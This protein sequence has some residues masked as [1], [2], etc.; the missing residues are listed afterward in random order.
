MIGNTILHY[1]ITKKLGEGGMGV[2]YKA[3]D[4]KLMREVALKF[5]SSQ[6][7]A[8]EEERDRFEREARAAAA[9]DHPNICPIYEI[10][11]ADGQRFIAMAFVEGE[12]LQSVVRQGPLPFRDILNYAI[13]IADGLQAA[14]EKGIVHRDVKP[15]NILFSGK[16][17]VRITDF[18][19]A[20]FAGQTE[21]TK[22]GSSLGTVAYMS[23]EQTQGIEVDHRTDVWALGAVIYEMITGKRPFVGDYDQAVIY[24]IINQDP[25]PPTGLRSGVPM[26]LE[27]IVSKSLAKNRDERYQHIEEMLVDLK[28]VQKTL[29]ASNSITSGSARTGAKNVPGHSSGAQGRSPK[30]KAGLLI[31]IPFVLILVVLAAYGFWGKRDSS[32]STINSIAVL[33][34]ADLSPDKDQEYFCDGMTEEILTKLSRLGRLKVIART[35]VMRYKNTKKSIKQIG[36]EL[37]VE[38]ILEGSIRK[39]GDEIRVTAQLIN[40]KD[41]SH[42]WAENYDRQFSGVFK[43]QDDI[44]RAIAEAL[45]GKLTSEELERFSSPQPRDKAAYELVLKGAYHIQNVFTRTREQHDFEVGINYFDQAIVLDSTYA[46]ALIEKAWAYHLRWV[47]GGFGDIE[48]LQLCKKFAEKGLSLAS[49]SARAYAMLATANITFG[50]P[51]KA[52]VHFKEAFR[53]NPNEDLAHHSASFF[54]LT[55]GMLEEALR[56]RAHALELDPNQPAYH[57]LLVDFLFNAGKLMD[58]EQVSNRF[59][60]AFPDDKDV[61][62][63]VT[64]RKA[65][66]YAFRGDLEMAKKLIAQVEPIDER[67]TNMRE[68]KAIVLALDGQ[69]DLALQTYE[70]AGIYALLGLQD[71]AIM[72]LQKQIEQEKGLYRSWYALIKNY[73]SLAP[74]QDNP[75]FLTILRQERAKAEQFRKK[76]GDL[77]EVLVEQ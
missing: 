68:V 16:R 29:E 42:L 3:E 61:Q 25:Q 6:A 58:A 18:G 30:S 40:A 70:D 46:S 60:A 55:H 22:E 51:D 77:V 45:R 34:F 73:P 38:S 66:F 9:L 14:H 41:E 59:A 47:V 13:Q 5:L 33:P 62:R 43:L 31:A 67:D 53:L 74:L 32:S 12:S 35:S 23:P 63:F 49:N 7:V 69:K 48:A 4:T 10:N 71:E 64:S 21:L 57:L 1:K 56:F 75:Q 20:K 24:S 26:E 76:Y 65:V 54:M 36:V 37:G 19:L 8:G 28:T 72:H 27:R 15:A 39:D 11:E 44:A 50:E 52:Y 17:L 2:V